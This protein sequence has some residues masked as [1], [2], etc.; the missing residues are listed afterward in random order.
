[1]PSSPPIIFYNGLPATWRRKQRTPYSG[2]GVEDRGFLGPQ[3]LPLTAIPGVFARGPLPSLTFQDG[4]AGWN[5]PIGL[6]GQ[7]VRRTVS[8]LDLGPRP[9]QASGTAFGSLRGRTGNEV[10]AGL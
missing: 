3:N 7:H 4:L 5:L 8:T 10:C 6:A 2:R 1:M 9:F